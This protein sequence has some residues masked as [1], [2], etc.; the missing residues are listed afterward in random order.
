MGKDGWSTLSARCLQLIRDLIVRMARENDW[1]LTRI[2]AE[3]KQLYLGPIGRTTVRNI[4][5][6]HGADRG[7]SRG[8]VTWDEFIARHAKTLWACDF[9]SVRTWTWP[10]K[11][12]SC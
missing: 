11:V 7:P 8:V 12:R 9:L 1:G 4:L 3:I 6:E 10:L 2:A 5:N